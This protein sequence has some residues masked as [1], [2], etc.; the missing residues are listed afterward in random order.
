MEERSSNSEETDTKF[1][2]LLAD[3][4]AGLSLTDEE[5]AILRSH[6]PY[7][8]DSHTSNSEHSQLESD[9]NAQR[10]EEKGIE[11]TTSDENAIPKSTLLEKSTLPEPFN[12]GEEDESSTQEYHREFD[13]FLS[14]PSSENAS[15]TPRKQLPNNSP[16]TPLSLISRGISLN[17]D[18]ETDTDEQLSPVLTAKKT[19]GDLNYPS[20]LYHSDDGS[21][22]E[23]LH[24]EQI[25]LSDEL[26]DANDENPGYL[27][28]IKEEG[29]SAYSSKIPDTTVLSRKISDI[30]IPASAMKE[31]EEKKGLLSKEIRDAPPGA[32][33]TLKEQANVI[34][35]LRKEAFG[36]KL[37]CF[38]L[39]DQL[40]KFHD[41]EVQDIMKQNIDLKTLTM[42][43]QRA[44][45]TYE[46]K[47][48]SYEKK[49][50]TAASDTLQSNLLDL[51]KKYSKTYSELE[52]TKKALTKAEKERRKQP[53][54]VYDPYHG[55]EKSTLSSLLDSERREKEAL[56]QEV[57]SL[58]SLL[59]QKSQIK[60]R[61]PDERVIQ[62]L[63]RT[64]DL[65]RK[66][67][68]AQN[69]AFLFQ[70]Q[71]KDKL[72]QEIEELKGNLD[73]AKL[74][75][76]AEAEAS[77]N[78]IWDLMMGCKMKTQ[79]QAV[80]LSR[81]YKQLEEIEYDC[82]NKLV[83]MEQQ[84]KDDVDQLQQYVEELTQD[85]QTAKGELTRS[86]SDSR[87]YEQALNDL[88][89]ETETELNQ[90][91]KTIR[92]NEESIGLFKEEIEKL[93]DELSHLSESYREKSDELKDSEIKIADFR[94][95]LED[96][97]MQSSEVDALNI[98][99][100][101]SNKLWQSA[102]EERNSLKEKLDIMNAEIEGMRSHKLESSE[103]ER[104]LQK[105]LEELIIE[106]DQLKHSHEDESKE[107]Y[108]L[109]TQLDEKKS[110][111]SEVAQEKATIMKKLEALE[112][113][114]TVLQNSFTS[115]QT[116]I[117]E[118]FDKKVEHCS[119][120]LLV[121]Q[122][123]K[124]KDESKRLNS[125]IEKST[126]QFSKNEQIIRERETSMETL[127]SEKKELKALL[128]S[129][130]RS[131]KVMQSELDALNLQNT[132]RSL[133][134]SSSPSERSQSREFKLLQTSE[135]RLKEQ[136]DERNKLIK[137]VISRLAQLSSSS[138][139]SGNNKPDSLTTFSSMNQA[140]HGQ[141]KEL[142]K[143]TQGFKKKC[144][145]MER[146]FKIEINKLDSNLEARSK[147]LSQ[148]EERFRLMN[149]S[150]L[151]S[152]PASPMSSKKLIAAAESPDDKKPPPD[153]SA[154]Q[155]GITALKRDAEGMSHIWQLRLR[156][157]EF[158]LK[159]EQEGRKHDKLGAR[160]RLQD[161]V[162]QNRSLSQRIT[163]DKNLQNSVS[164]HE[165]DS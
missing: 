75:A 135:K 136:I 155:R 16:L 90:F 24:R 138:A 113:R 118:T 128:D 99:L 37:K 41:S 96:S 13:R 148:L 86:V 34:D 162:K 4:F 6:L 14:S 18:D 139:I 146:D 52:S 63:Q 28:P 134:S 125:E 83:K 132:R 140:M 51:Q 92:E 1:L 143:S 10:K 127:Q 101:N 116:A 72:M 32:S 158:Q 3:D 144:K 109:S 150:T 12:Q 19:Y 161:L 104:E 69:E 145:A 107:I 153:R 159:A 122:V 105:Q 22:N 81:L 89:R 56:L 141:L 102:T 36:L 77:K 93:T 82:E 27:T 53:N 142:E 85:L 149:V 25:I 164:S 98:Q 160:E 20:T 130:R 40:N 108:V 61:T 50:S 30:S 106:I 157:L 111:L 67:L 9:Y 68:G 73:A 47:I 115:L 80:E 17:S 76:V 29:S 117:L 31:L 23:S 103:R 94:Q 66:D 79:E 45:A 26:E 147:K 15:A 54:S 112:N 152:R 58:R 114:Y 91:D 151:G 71:E 64:N 133:S 70:M 39:Y 57:D 129:E 119:A 55:N 124:L 154:V 78:E 121:R 123:K 5:V 33:L 7:R 97:K 110:E 46:K 84:W 21:S 87:A 42:Q 62:S 163:L 100:E 43:L 49:P 120:E 44:V 38:F 59:A 35:N 131:K 60:P 11:N 8:K 88:R 137:T 48:S 65:L 126:R 165:A 74:N 156:E 95:K 2:H